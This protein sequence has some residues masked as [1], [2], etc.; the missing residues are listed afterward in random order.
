[1][2]KLMLHDSAEHVIK[3]VIV[4]GLAGDLILQTGVRKSGDGFHQ[5]IVSLLEM[6]EGLTPS[7][8]S[9]VFHGR[10]ILLL[11]QL[12]GC[13]TDAAT[14]GIVPSGDMQDKLPNAVGIFNWPGRSGCGRHTRE[15]LPD[16]IAVPG[17]AIQASAAAWSARLPWGSSSPTGARE[18]PGKRSASIT[19]RSWS[20]AGA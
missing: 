11:G 20:V 1:M 15:Q 13:P 2:I 4:L 19:R 17:I 14:D 6:A 5:L 18:L 7:G 9:G 3:I 10:E 16:G 8:G 12:D